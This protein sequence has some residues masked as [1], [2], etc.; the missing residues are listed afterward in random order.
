M[1]KLLSRAES[2]CR[3]K[4]NVIGRE[5]H[6]TKDMLHYLGFTFKLNIWVYITFG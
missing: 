3:G 4:R 5:A 1:G 6:F 2:E